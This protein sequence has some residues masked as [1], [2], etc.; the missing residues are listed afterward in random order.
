MGDQQAWDALV[1]RYAS[2]IWSTCR[3]Y[4]LNEA[5]A[6]DVG[7]CVWLQFVEH[8]GTIRDPAALP[9]WLV[10][11][12]RRE[13]A[14]VLRSARRAQP[15]NY[16]RDFERIAEQVSRTAEEEILAAERHAA[17]REA[18]TDLPPAWRRLMA[19]LAADPPVPYAEISSRLGIAVG[20]IGPTRA[21]CLDRIRRH[22]AIAALAEIMV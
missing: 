19:M 11:T 15:G 18:L 10:T 12:T 8:V 2:L 20:S 22:P 21:R 14:R 17:L 7:Q 6:E 13:C 16:G 4:R 9:G 3:R 1:E 5:D